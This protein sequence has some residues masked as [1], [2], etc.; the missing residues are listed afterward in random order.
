MANHLTLEE[1][2]RIA[3]LRPPDSKT[4][5]R[6]R[7]TEIRRPGK[8]EENHLLAGCGADVMVHGHDLDA[9][10][11]MDHRFHDRSGRFDQMGPNLLQQVPALFGRKRLDQVLLGGGQDALETHDEEITKQVGANILRTPA[12]VILLEAADPFANGGFD[13]SVGFHGNRL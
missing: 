8:G 4:L 10:D 2:D 9:G 13:L 7:F 12:H 11:L 6:L 3:Q 5:S 1:R